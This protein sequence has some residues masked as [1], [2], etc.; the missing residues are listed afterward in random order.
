MNVTYQGQRLLDEY[1]LGQLVENS[2]NAY[3]VR[4]LPN[5]EGEGA[6]LVVLPLDTNDAKLGVKDADSVVGVIRER[7]TAT[8]KTFAGKQEAFD[9]ALL[10]L[11]KLHPSIHIA[12]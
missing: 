3:W 9:Y 5:P 1:E 8:P 11:R 7:D 10:Y 12:G 4:C 6:I 2:E